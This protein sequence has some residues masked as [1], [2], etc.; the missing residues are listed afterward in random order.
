MP[1]LLQLQKLLG[2]GDGGRKTSVFVSFFLLTRRSQFR[3][4]NAFWGILYH[5]QQFVACCQMHA[6]YRPPKMPLKLAV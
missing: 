1:P 2:K 5:E 3:G 6:D 4:K